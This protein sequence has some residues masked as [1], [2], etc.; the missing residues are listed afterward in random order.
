MKFTD[1]GLHSELLAGIEKAGYVECTPVQAQVFAGSLDG[2][3]LYVQSQ[4][5]TGK[6]AAYLIT[7]LQQLLTKA[8]E[9]DAPKALI[10]VPTRELAVQ[11]ESETKL[12][13]CGTKLKCAS[14]YGGVGYDEQT[15]V[16]HDKVDIIVGTPGRVIDLQKS[17]TMDLSKIS[18]LVIDEADRMFDM[19]F[20]PDLRELLKVLPKKDAR[21][22]MLF[23]ATLNTYIKNLA[24][25]Y[26][27][28]PKEITIEAENITVTEIAQQLYHVSSNDKLRLLL[29]IL[30]REKP[31]SVIVFCNTK[32]TCEIVSKRLEIN[33]IKNDFIIGD[34]PQSKRLQVL[35]A[36]KDGKVPCLIAT[37]VAARGIDVENLAMVINYDIPNEAENYVH[38]IGRTARAGKS[39]HA[40]SFCSEKDV[41]DLLPIER[42]IEMQIPAVTAEESLF[43]EDKSVGIYIKTF[44]ERNDRTRSDRP[45]PDRG[46]S[47]PY[48]SDRNDRSNRPRY[49][50]PDRGGN[51]PDRD[52]SNRSRAAP[53]GR[54]GSVAGDYRNDGAGNTR[55]NQAQPNTTRQADTHRYD[56]PQNRQKSPR[57]QN[58]GNPQGQNRHTQGQPRRENAPP[59]TANTN[60]PQRGALPQRNAPPQ[61]QSP[62]SQSKK[63]GFIAKIKSLFGK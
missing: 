45:R 29:G 51:R 31:E 43:V 58:Q 7:I 28:D 46:G 5:G 26:T 22:T 59:H 49:D 41:Y 1:F 38:R 33:G 14:F 52:R 13:A 35:N 42:Y 61:T 30:A 20:Y 57:A 40:Y 15:Q 62:S 9:T 54:T 37:D 50:S 63:S 21:Q 55:R 53:A 11:V 12:L 24:W 56:K 39:G 25:E 18:F 2:T 47:S 6:T 23:S 36:F 32:K 19:G 48:R 4:T 34:L 17:R 16:L 27:T 44:D 60:A 10:M 3:D 8:P